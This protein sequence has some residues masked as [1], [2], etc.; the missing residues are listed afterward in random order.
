MNIEEKLQLSENINFLPYIGKNYTESKLK[1]L[2]LGESHYGGKEK[3]VNKEWTRQVVRD[4][5]LEDLK[6][7]NKNKW[8]QVYRYTAAMITG[9]GYH[10]SDYIW[11]DMVFYNFFQ[12]TVGE[13]SSNKQFITEDLISKSRVAFF[14]VID[15]FKP[16]IV[17][18][19][20]KTRLQNEWLP[21]EEKEYLADDLFIYEK[22]PST[23]LWSI[24][25]PSK[26]F[27][28]NEYH[29]KWIEVVD[30]YLK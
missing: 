22:N 3:N 13:G 11:D 16:D 26:G 15:L 7:G 18:I 5:Y 9:K 4:E 27:S 28:Y 14:E 21:Q 25:H 19:W 10:E 17:I 8:T 12:E 2:V 6:K 29:K 30:K 20:G 23:I 1:I 24:H